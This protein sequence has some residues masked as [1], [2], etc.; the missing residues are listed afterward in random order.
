MRFRIFRVGVL[1]ALA[2]LAVACSGGGESTGPDVG[3]PPPPPPPPPPTTGTI[4]GRVTSASGAA[5][6]GASVSTQPSTAG[7]TTDAQGNYSIANVA[8]GAY[9]VTV[10]KNGFQSGTMNVSV[11]AGQT[12]SANLSLLAAA[13]PFSYTQTAQ[14]QATGTS[15]GNGIASMAISPDGRTLAYAT[16]VDNL[17]RLVDVAS[18]QEVRTLSGHTNRVTEM[19]FSP[20]SR[21]LA[22]SGTTS[23]SP[24]DGSV[25]IWEVSTGTQLGTVATPGTRHLT[26][27]PNGSQLVGASLGDPVS[28]R[29]WNAG[30]LT[31]VR[32]IT[33]V[34]RFSAL[35]PDG[36]RLAAGARNNGLHVVDFTSG[37]AI[38]THAGQTGWVTAAAYS[39]NGQLLA[40][41]SEDRTILLRN[42]QTGAVGSTLS[43][44]TS[45]P[46]VLEFSPDGAALAS[47]GSGTNVMRNGSQVSISIGNADRFI[48][49]WNL[50]TGIEYPRVNVSGDV[51]AAISFSGD[52]QRLV[53]GSDAGV[54]RIFVRAG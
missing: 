51:V 18:R 47:L 20:D 49:I 45:Y 37:T 42:A 31:P 6:D 52:W 5:I 2:T 11:V 23:L 33:G 43:G 34:F 44:H 9:V 38:A 15:A 1:I 40:S 16:F 41:A 10:A 19:V 30:G 17:I 8:P 12:A 21:L 25:R 27:T 7:A 4:S 28:I 13:L 24:G 39:A 29:V 3:N 32:T 46:D 53:T 35:H 26:F 48:R 14:L 50:S 22:S 36:S 54:I